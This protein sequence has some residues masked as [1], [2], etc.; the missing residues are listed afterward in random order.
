MQSMTGFGRFKTEQDGRKITLEIKSVNHRFLDINIRLPR[1]L[2]FAED[3]I[4]KII[5]NNIARGRIDVFVN[6]TE[7]LGEEKK[8]VAD[9]S[10][11]ASFID[12]ARKAAQQTGLKDD[13][14][15]S[16]IIA[17][18][19]IISVEEQIEDEKKILN[20]LSVAVCSAMEQLK[21]MRAHEGAQLKKSIKECTDALFNICGLIKRRSQGNA[22]EYA[23]RLREKIAALM[24]SE[25][26]ETRFATE[27]AIMAE[28]ADITEELV[29]LNAHLTQ[30]NQ[31]IECET[32]A[33][34]KLDFLVQE[35]N[36]EANTIGS[37][38][39]DIE[40]TRL[41]VEAKSVI[42]KMREQVQN[43]E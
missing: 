26:D 24:E 41:V 7:T 18:P 3:S 12:S 30:I 14:S 32:A 8:A 34:R 6:Y 37:K 16:H 19:G 42:E 2:L 39:C 28:R 5:S 27:V 36:R 1:I 22:K 4:R 9:L 20:V 23:E 38:A 33:G 35:L 40:I 17:I 15:L 31:I 13:L 21:A 29:R 43:I 25:T 11:L 10:F